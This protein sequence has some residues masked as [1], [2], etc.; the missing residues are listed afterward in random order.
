MP[1]YS[2]LLAILYYFMHSS[3]IHDHQGLNFIIETQ[4]DTIMRLIDR[5]RDPK[6]SNNT[7][8]SFVNS[9]TDCH[10]DFQL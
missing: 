2:I 9:L 10:I 4:K 5:H 7:M 3:Y 1:K 8:T 6:Y